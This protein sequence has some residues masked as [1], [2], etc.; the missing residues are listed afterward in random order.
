MDWKETEREKA[1]NQGEMG[2]PVSTTENRNFILLGKIKVKEGR[3]QSSKLYKERER[4]S[5]QH[6]N[7]RILV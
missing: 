7:A 2:K 3:R 1:S 5:Q 6:G 4:V